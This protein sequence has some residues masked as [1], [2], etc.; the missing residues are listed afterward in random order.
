MTSQHGGHSV[1][2]A[3]NGDHGS[4]AAVLRRAPIRRTGRAVT[5]NP[6]L[7]GVSVQQLGFA[8]RL[9]FQLRRKQ[10]H[11]RSARWQ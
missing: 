3:T 4:E 1:H 5:G 10:L 11:A 6:T 7:L 8:N 2:A 9:P